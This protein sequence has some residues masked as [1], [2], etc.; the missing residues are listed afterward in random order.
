MEIIMF[1]THNTEIDIVINTNTR[2][3]FGCLPHLAHLHVVRV[4]VDHFKNLV[5]RPRLKATLAILNRQEVVEDCVP[6]R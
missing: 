2:T 5:F 4:E 1:T 3:P 6:G